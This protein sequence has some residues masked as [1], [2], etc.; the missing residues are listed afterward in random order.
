MKKYSWEIH[1]KNGDILTPD[2]ASMNEWYN[3]EEEAREWALEALSACHAGAEIF[4][5]SNPGDYPEP[6]EDDDGDIYIFDDSDE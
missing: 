5:M 6:D 3:S 4:H 2:D 1:F